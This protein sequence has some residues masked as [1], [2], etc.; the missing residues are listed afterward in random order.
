[1]RIFDEEI[2]NATWDSAYQL[3]DEP[4]PRPAGQTDSMMVTG[5]SEDSTYFFSLMACDEADNCSWRSNCA[6]ATCFDDYIVTFPDTGLEAAV[7][8]MIEK[9]TGDIHRIDLMTFVFLDANSAG[10]ADLTGLEHCTN[11]ETIFASG[12]SISNLAPLSGLW[13]LRA[14]QLVGNDIS[15]F[16]SVA[17]LPNLAQLV[18]RSNPLTDISP[19][20]G[21]AG[22][23]WLDLSQCNLT[24]I[25]PLVANPNL[26]SGDT[27]YVI[28]N[29]LSQEALSTQIPALE[30]RGVTVFH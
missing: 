4:A 19:V 2:T 9:P 28:F 23:H 1:M 30:A 21:M 22:L 14:I 25:A 7:R 27:V 10:I 13:R 20:S 15:T 24:D 6:R 8:R 12:N 17:D 26:A 29:P 3:T 18:L 11:L 5:L 16:A